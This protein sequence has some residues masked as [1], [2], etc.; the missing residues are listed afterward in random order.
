[1]DRRVT[2]RYRYDDGRWQ[3]QV[4]DRGPDGSYAAA[5]DTRLDEGKKTGA[6]QVAVFAGDD[7]VALAPV[8][9]VPRLDL[10]LV[11]ADITPPA[12]VH[13]INQAKINLTERP[14]VMPFGSTI[15]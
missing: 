14:A 12:Y 4:M 1:S 15:D 7:E 6:M 10:S 9:I 11:Q 2:V 5:L 8:T 3:E 13:A